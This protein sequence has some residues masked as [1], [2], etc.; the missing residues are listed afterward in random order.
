[1]KNALETRKTYNKKNRPAWFS[2]EI[3]S[4]GLYGVI[5][6]AGQTM[7]ATGWTTSPL[8]RGKGAI[9]VTN[10]KPW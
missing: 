5:K 2:A 6:Y 4:Y 1:M 9:N 7:T 3:A 8:Q 10:D